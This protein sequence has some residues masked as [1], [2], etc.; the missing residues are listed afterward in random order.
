MVFSSIIFLHFFFPLF[1]LLYF[2]TPPRGRNAL[3]LAASLFFYTWGEQV[4]VLVMLASTA[5][6]YLCGRT[7]T[8]EFETAE[9]FRDNPASRMRTR[10][11]RTALWVSVGFNLSLLS[12]FKYFN[13]GAD[14]FNALMSA[15]GWDAWVAEDL[16][17]IIL[18]LGISF[19]TFQSLSYTI[20]CYR[21]QVSAARNF[22]DFACFV[23]M[24]PQ[25]I[26]GPI[27]RYRDVETHL[28]RRSVS[29]ADFAA[30]S[31]QF[32]IG[33]GK[34][35]L[36]ANT[37]AQPV[38]QI[39]ALP[40]DQVTPLLAW[41]GAVLFTFQLYFDFA[42]YSDMAIGM[43]RMLG[44]RF[45]ENFRY[46]FIA[47]TVSEFWTRWH[48][49]LSTWIRDYLFTPMGGYR[50][51]R[52]RGYMNLIVAFVLCGLWHGASW[53]F[54]L[55]GLCQ[56]LF[57]TFERMVHSN[58]RWFFKGPCGHLYFLPI[59]LTQMMLFRS[60]SLAGA[61]RFLRSMLGLYAGS[62]LSPSIG[63]F[64]TGEVSLAV[65]AAFVGSAPF[66]PWCAARIERWAAA[67][68]PARTARRA[69]AA[70]WAAAALLACI[71]AACI[72]KLASGTYNPFIY[73]RF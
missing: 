70:D 13:F 15:L 63:Q 18:P 11:Q 22:V 40:L 16:V 72:L 34:K 38:D 48:I 41:T 27:V 8:R 12:V 33:L 64:F 46:P 3:L 43:G 53:N 55:F 32:I 67:G 19:Y 42:G 62:S 37:V 59:L 52:W 36:I 58:R 21:R 65:V 39:F 69:A 26:A 28:V 17:E 51:G 35:V 54:V 71:L 66:I 57:M 23:T 24:F 44:F 73:F 14:N 50:H 9:C 20:D 5:V 2:A 6:D 68:S 25:L 31:R 60:E 30:G 56:G 7:I 49:T 1:L 10:R 61:G 4:L 29:L 47:R 45:P